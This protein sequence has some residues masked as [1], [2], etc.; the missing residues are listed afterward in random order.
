MELLL[1]ELNAKGYKVVHLKAKDKAQ[2]LPAWDEIAKA[3]IKGPVV[4]S[5]RPTSSVVR[6]IS[7]EKA[8]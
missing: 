5:D 6:T 3:E 8:K 7:S 1:K 4:G 2:S